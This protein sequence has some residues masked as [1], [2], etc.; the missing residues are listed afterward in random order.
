MGKVGR[1]EDRGVALEFNL[2]MLTVV[3]GFESS[4]FVFAR[5]IELQLILR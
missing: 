4:P 3:E 5:I 1:E 2:L